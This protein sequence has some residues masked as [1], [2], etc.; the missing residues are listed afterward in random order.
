MGKKSVLFIVPSITNNNGIISFIKNY[1]SNEK[2]FYAPEDIEY[3][4]RAWSKGYYVAYLKTHN[5]THLWQRLSRKKLFS[6]HN[7]EHLKGLLYFSFKHHVVFS[8]K[9]INLKIKKLNL[10]L[11]KNEND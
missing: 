8:A 9:K 10:E 4:V 3:C 11:F 5:L 7:L 2:L 1:I 6:K